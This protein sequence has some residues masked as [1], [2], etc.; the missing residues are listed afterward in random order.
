MNMKAEIRARHLRAEKCQR[1]SVNHHE[2]GKRH[3]TE[4][5]WQSSEEVCPADSVI[6][7]FW[8]PGLGGLVCGPLCGRGAWWATVHRVT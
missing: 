4:S 6:S 3:E 2:L 5:A 7:D 1:L 8:P